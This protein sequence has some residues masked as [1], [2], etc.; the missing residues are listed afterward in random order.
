MQSRANSYEQ[1]RYL[2]PVV[3]SVMLSLLSGLY[4]LLVA[5]KT[6]WMKT[7]S[8]L[9]DPWSVAL[10]AIGL[11]G[12][13]CAL[14][15]TFSVKFFIKPLLI[16]LVVSAAAASWYMDVYGVIIDRE[17]VR[18]AMETTSSEASH[19]ITFGFL[20]HMTLFAV[21]PVFL[22]CWIKVEHRSF[23]QKAKVNLAIIA[24]CLAVSSVAG[25]A[26]ARTFAAT[27]RAHRDMMVTLNP[28]SPIFQVVRYIAGNANKGP[29]VVK[30]RGIDAHVTGIKA[31][32]SRPN[33]TIIVAGETARAENFA[34]N[35]YGRQTNP[36]LSRQDIAYFLDT[37]SCG[38]A[39]AV[40]L[41][42]MFSVFGRNGYSHEK[43]LSTENLVDV[44]SHAGIRT[45]WWDNNT[46]SKA[47]ANRISYRSFSNENNPR[48]CKDKECLDEGML[49]DLDGWLDTVKGDSVLVL[50][51]IG[52]H[53]PA[54]YQR[55]PE[56]FRRFTPDCRTAE[57]GNCSREEI[58][59]AYDNTILYTDHFLSEIIEKLKKREKS[60]SGSMVYMS[61]HGESLGEKGIYLHGAPY[62]IAPS[63]QTH[64]PFIVW[65]GQ[66][67]KRT[68]DSA[69]LI[70]KT[71]QPQSHDNLFST[72]LG[73]MNVE[74]VEYN[75][76]LDILASCRNN[77]TS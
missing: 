26:G 49:A 54:Y 37:A 9:G 19:L 60:I 39:T 32:F 57:L 70:G 24:L 40:S 30:A 58:I 77:L 68:V 42:C 56:N 71:T 67:S 18:N 28:F 47:V 66:G 75:H 21:L 36:E 76:R 41:P 74:T 33:V 63:Q 53:G 12:L 25:F 8:Y 45:E 51:Q 48:F 35:G 62:I 73:M 22:I 72:V 59:N 65:L 17:M 61:D 64:I 69:C 7:L 5:N 23:G 2:R 43:G 10:L 14:L 44:L 31:T 1:S 55:Y 34:L 38:T 15:V 50:H 13:Y 6:F 20:R 11:G 4:L 29:I 3:G 27:T 46:G 52:S 16:F